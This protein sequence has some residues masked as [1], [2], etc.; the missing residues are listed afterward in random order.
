MALGQRLLEPLG[1]RWRHSLAV[2]ERAREISQTLPA[3]SDRETL[4]AA[5]L[6]HDIGYAPALV[7]TGFHAIDG[8]RYMR[9][10]GHERLACLVA[11]HSG[12][13]QEAALRGLSEELATFPR[14]E[15]T[16]AE[17]LTYCDATTGL[18][19]Q[20]LTLPER[21]ADIEH[22][23]GADHLVTRAVHAAQSDLEAAVARTERRLAAAGLLDAATR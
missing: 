4:V 9:E 5:A 22:R 11:H 6:L 19:G 23:Y 15:S 8:G 20:R 1:A 21:V 3:S 2:G 14:E 18:N 10:Q 16:L 13:R 7:R 12:A 17:A